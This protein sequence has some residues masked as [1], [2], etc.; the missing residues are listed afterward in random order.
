[1]AG[2]LGSTIDIGTSIIYPTAIPINWLA[3]VTTTKCIFY[4]VRSPNDNISC[5]YSCRV[6]TSVNSGDTGLSTTIND[7]LCLLIL[8]RQVVCLV[9]ATIDC[10][11]LIILMS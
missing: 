1:M 10:L 5:R 6:T 2:N 8:I 9:T 3:T 11:N 7:D 4:I